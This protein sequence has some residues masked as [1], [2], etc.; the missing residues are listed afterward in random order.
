MS[1]D[2]PLL[3]TIFTVAISLLAALLGL[4]VLFRGRRLPWL[5]SGAAAFLLGVLLVRILEVVMGDPTDSTS[6]IQWEDWIPIIAGVVGGVAGR[7]RLD[8]A[9][10][11]I[12]WRRGER[13]RSG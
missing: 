4:V 9:Y 6:R 10:E 7:I 11:V 1:I 5:F 2:S 8:V 13:W 12:G 3:S